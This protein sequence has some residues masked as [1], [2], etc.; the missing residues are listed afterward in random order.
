MFGPTEGDMVRLGGTLLWIEVKRNETFYGDETKFGGGLCALSWQASEWL[1]GLQRENYLQRYG[2]SLPINSLQKHK[3]SSVWMCSLLV[4]LESAR[5]STCLHYSCKAIN[6]ELLEGREHMVGLVLE[7][8]HATDP[9][10]PRSWMRLLSS[11]RLPSLI[12]ILLHYL[13]A[14][15]CFW[16]LLKLPQNLH[17]YIA[18][19]TIHDIH[20]S[21]LVFA[22]VV[23][24]LI[25]SVSRVTT[26]RSVHTSPFPCSVMAYPHDRDAVDLASC[27]SL[28]IRITN[29]K[30]LLFEDWGGDHSLLLNSSRPLARSSKSPSIWSS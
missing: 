17:Q 23:S 19:Q 26:M 27:I 4:G 14:L 9:I 5:H 22:L 25:M 18:C 12:T 11:G 13:I 1:T 6:K 8:I 16:H 2:S 28:Q 30:N 7:H 21:V 10:F 15:R 3:I 20:A 29:C 24:S